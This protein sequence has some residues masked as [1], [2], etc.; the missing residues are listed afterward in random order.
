ME[1]SVS[2]LERLAGALTKAS[3]SR[4]LG[5]VAEHGHFVLTPS[6]PAGILEVVERQELAVRMTYGQAVGEPAQATHPAARDRGP[7]RE[8]RGAVYHRRGAYNPARR[9][10]LW[11]RPDPVYPR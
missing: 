5:P 2:M 8:P 3:S 9:E 6:T 10:G 1:T 7:E 11:L 4:L